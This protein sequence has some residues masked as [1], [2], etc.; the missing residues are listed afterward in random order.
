MT[1]FNEPSGYSDIFIKPPLTRQGLPFASAAPTW[2]PMGTVAVGN[3]RFLTFAVQ[4]VTPIIVLLVA[5]L[6]TRM[7]TNEVNPQDGFD[8]RG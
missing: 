3:K 7:L 8:V 4:H 5:L 1:I 6:L 2:H